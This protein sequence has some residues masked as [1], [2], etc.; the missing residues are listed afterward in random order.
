[1][2][3]H[4]RGEGYSIRYDAVNLTSSKAKFKRVSKITIHPEYQTDGNRLTSNDIAILQLDGEID[5]TSNVVPV[6]MPTKDDTL[7]SKTK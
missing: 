3:F 6:Q 4:F 7:F 1:M 5:S 2:R